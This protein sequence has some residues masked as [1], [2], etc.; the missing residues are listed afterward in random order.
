M[1]QP[2]P[3]TADGSSAPTGAG[4]VVYYDGSCPMCQREI[5]WYRRLPAQNPIEWIDVSAVGYCAPE[6]TTTDLLMKRLHAVTPTGELVS[7]ARAFAHIWLQLPGWRVIG[8][9]VKLPG[10]LPI[11]ELAYR[12]FLPVRPFIQAVFRFRKRQLSIGKP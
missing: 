4:S 11:M 6:G 3:L 9:L 2:T 8:Q 5:A 7:G 1:N 10:A 12:L